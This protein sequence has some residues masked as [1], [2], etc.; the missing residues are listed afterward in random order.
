MA[1]GPFS[2]VWPKNNT[3]REKIQT[4]LLETFP[5]VEYNSGAEMAG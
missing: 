1:R 5:A 4:W 2:I 3:G